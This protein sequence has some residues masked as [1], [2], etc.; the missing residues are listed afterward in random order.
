MKMK[1][2]RRGSLALV[3]LLTGCLISGTFVIVIGLT[4]L[5]TTFVNGMVKESVNLA[6][7]DETWEDHAD[8]IKR[9]DKITFDAIVTNTL[10]TATTLNVYI[11]DN[12][13]YASGAAV[14][15]GVGT[16][17]YEVLIG[18]IT[19]PNATDTLTVVEADALL[20]L[21][22]AN[23]EGVKALIESGVFCVYVTSSAS[24]AQGQIDE[25]NV[26][27]TFTAGE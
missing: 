13:T 24:V 11:S 5:A 26:Y 27:I 19:K 6:A 14:M 21:T 22:G 1:T 23:F 3:L 9:I 25:A 7:E 4:G 12:A 2:L 17:V 18:Y 16:D 20:R 15:A 10:S 8:D